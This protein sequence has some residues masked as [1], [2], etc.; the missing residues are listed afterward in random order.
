LLSDTFLVLGFVLFLGLPLVTI[1]T[2]DRGL[3]KHFSL[4]SFGTASHCPSR[5]PDQRI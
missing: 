4:K 2:Q 3:A 1:S 5:A